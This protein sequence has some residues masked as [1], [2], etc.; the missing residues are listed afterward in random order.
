MITSLEIENF[1]AIGEPVR[2]DIRPITLL[3]GPNSSGKS[4][5]IQALHYLRHL[6]LYE[7]SDVDR[8]DQVS[9]GVDLGGFRRLVHGHDLDKAIRIRIEHTRKTWT[10]L[11]LWETLVEPETI[12]SLEIP[13]AENI[14]KDLVMSIAME[15]EVRW[16]HM[17]EMPYVPTYRV[18]INGVQA[19][20][21]TGDSDKQH[22]RLKSFSFEA[23]FDRILPL[24]DDENESLRGLIR[25]LDQYLGEEQ[26]QPQMLSLLAPV[27][28]PKRRVI[29]DPQ[30]RNISWL[31]PEMNQL[32]YMG[33]EYRHELLCLLSALIVGPSYLTWRELK[34]LRYIG[35][36]REIPPRSLQEIAADDEL[37]WNRGLAA[38]NYLFKLG[39]D[40]VAEI[41]E[42]LSREDRLGT[43]Y[44]VKIQSV[45]EMADDVLLSRILEGDDYSVLD[46]LRR[47]IRDT[48]KKKRVLFTEEETG[49]ELHPSEVGTGLSQVL[50]VVVAALDPARRFVAIEQPE[51]HVHPAVQVGLGDLLIRGIRSD[52]DEEKEN[53][54][55]PP[56]IFLIETHS[57][58]LMLRL[59]RRIEETTD[60]MHPPHLRPFVPRELS[61]NYVYK[62]K[63]HDQLCI[64]NLRV[65]ER[66]EF[67]DEW[68]H[69]FFGERGDEL[70]R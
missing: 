38:W 2:I 27:T 42:W 40:Q 68:P 39:R 35:P 60:G 69:G 45:V 34:D 6:V 1:K 48:P 46:S 56:P 66:G 62:D 51:L 67:L 61:V 59:L 7:S 30:A 57:E 8:T 18:F 13:Q 32:E 49:L 36:L 14:L 70:F 26:M 17:K 24:H 12:D 10:D 41:S 65:D 53:A 63:V 37:S 43:G 16:S 47:K 20:E 9:G 44:G 33:V 15:V 52:Y 31:V 5:I 64:K 19:A 4:T 23:A 11:W 50:P 28:N 55:D 58:H 25:D 29:P 3:F 21:I 54:L 22:I